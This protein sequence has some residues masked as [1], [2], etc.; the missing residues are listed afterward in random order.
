MFLFVI[1][2]GTKFLVS[3]FFLL[4]LQNCA[5]VFQ[6][7]NSVRSPQSAPSPVIVSV[8]FSQDVS[9]W[10]GGIADY[11]AETTPDDVIRAQGPLPAP[12]NGS[13]FRISGTNESDDLFIYIK[14]QISGLQPGQLYDIEF[15]VNIVSGEATGCVGVGGSP[16]DSVWVHAGATSFEPQTILQMGDFRVN[17]DRGNQSMGGI[18]GVVLGTIANS[19]TDCSQNIFEAKLLATH[20]P[21]TVTADGAGRVWIHVGMDSGFEAYSE[22]YLQSMNVIFKPRL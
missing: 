1:S 18:Q 3:L 12:L 17:I 21:H 20:L 15:Q 2:Q 11:S 16:G 9:S 8:N 10:T 7:E 4:S 5:P 6:E 13:G 14:R 22:I 19:K